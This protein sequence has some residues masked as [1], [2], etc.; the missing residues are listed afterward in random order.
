VK[1]RIKLT[2][3]IIDLLI[4]PK[5]YLSCIAR[6]PVM[7]PVSHSDIL[8]LA[9]GIRITTS[10]AATV[11]PSIMMRVMIPKKLLLIKTKKNAIL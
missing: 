10:V 1:V 3:T 2:F 7:K 8:S 5:K 6:S 9:A 11:R 4:L